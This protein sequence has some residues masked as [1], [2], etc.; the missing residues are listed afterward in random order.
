MIR[1]IGKRLG[2]LLPHGRFAR[3]AAVLA[4]SN[5]LGQVL[6]LA[7]SP[8]LTRLYTPADFGVLAVYMSITTIL[9]VVLALRYELAISLPDAH[10][11]ATA[12]L[13]L[14]LGFVGLNTLIGLV[15]VL[16]FRDAIAGL[17]NSPSLA[18]LLLLL[19]ASILLLGAFT[20]FRFWC[21]RTG[22]FG[23]V[24]RAR[25]WQ[26]LAS[27]AVQLLGA[28][29]GAVA[30]IAGQVANQGAGTV[31]LGRIARRDGALAP[32]TRADL[33]RV[34]VRYR[35][36]PLISS[37]AAL[38]NRISAQMPTML[39]AVYFGPVPAGLYALAARVLNTPA[40]VVS[41]AVASAFLSSASEKARAGTLA[42]LVRKA[43]ET[44]CAL[45]MPSLVLI[46]IVSPDVFSVA[47]GVEWTA[48]GDLARWLALLVYFSMVASPLT[49]LFPVL[50]RQMEDLVFQLVV[51]ALRTGAIVNGARTGDMQS[52]LA[53]YVLASS[54]C[55]I[56]FL[57]W[58]GIRTGI[59]IGT[60]ARSTLAVAARSAA[61]CLPAA[62]GVLWLDG[63]V[64]W[65]AGAGV[66]ALLVLIHLLSLGKAIKGVRAR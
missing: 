30:L 31:T 6:A 41:G 47:F 8:L 9:G 29:L 26:V 43:H 58:V 12:V 4:G 13:M 10:R 5:A 63:P 66:S 48:A 21:I 24:G 46:A 45:S 62:I 17:F 60:M 7:A 44:L 23:P 53:A 34:L 57:G 16:F 28:P 19:P 37:W 65:F 11:D 25:L 35:H 59:G 14:S 39:F 18:P 38:L 2:A 49:M 61:M 55:Y 22:A 54:V 36:F 32:V 51:F 15:A 1:A 27:L 20:V 33:R 64:A 42:G 56:G 3:G 40:A 52:T 50:E